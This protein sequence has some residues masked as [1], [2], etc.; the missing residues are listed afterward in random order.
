MITMICRFATS[1]PLLY[2]QLLFISAVWLFAATYFFVKRNQVL[3]FIISFILMF[4][5]GLMLTWYYHMHSQGLISLTQPVTLYA[6]PGKKYHCVHNIDVPTL[7]CVK[8]ESGRWMCV[9]HDCGKG[10]LSL[11]QQI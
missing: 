6:G 2:W 11:E 1:M 8:K 10:W 4:V 5:A 3:F 9:E 7:C